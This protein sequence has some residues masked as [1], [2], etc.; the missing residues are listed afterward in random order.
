M[1]WR[2]RSFGNLKNYK[3]DFIFFFLSFY[4]IFLYITSLL[5]K[6]HCFVRLVSTD[7]TMKFHAIQLE[8]LIHLFGLTIMDFD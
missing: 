8:E 1:F 4:N 2:D 3:H 7:F 6:S 5:Y